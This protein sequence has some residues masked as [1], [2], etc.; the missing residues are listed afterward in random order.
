MNAQLIFYA[1]RNVVP[2]NVV[3]VTNLVLKANPII[4]TY[5]NPPDLH[6]YRYDTSKSTYIGALNLN[7]EDVCTGIPDTGPNM[8]EI[9]C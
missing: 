9:H 8:T 6:T 5:S 3:P 1:D 7:I 4:H 2:N